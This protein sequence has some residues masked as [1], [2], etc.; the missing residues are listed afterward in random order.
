MPIHALQYNDVNYRRFIE[1]FCLTDLYEQNKRDIAR[2]DS[3]RGHHLPMVEDFCYV[4]LADL[5]S[6]EI[7]HYVMRTRN[8]SEIPLELSRNR[9]ACV[10]GD[11][12][13]EINLRLYGVY[14]ELIGVRKEE[15]FFVAGDFRSALAWVLEARGADPDEIERT[16]F[17]FQELI[18][19]RF[20]AHG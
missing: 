20:A 19:E 15:D 1:P 3:R 6:Q 7:S 10:T 18:E 12:E 11:L 16:T 14:A 17:R 13:A 4:D 2:T 5:T 8:S 9:V